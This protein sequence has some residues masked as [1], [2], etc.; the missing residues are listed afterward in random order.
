MGK[1]KVKGYVKSFGRMPVPPPGRVVENRK[2]KGSY[3]RSRV[4]EEAK[5]A[6]KEQLQEWGDGEGEGLGF[7]GD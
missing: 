6:I 2:G 1:R 3:K 4:K 5:R 7:E